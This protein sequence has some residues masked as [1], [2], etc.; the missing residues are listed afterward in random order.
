MN[1]C[2][3]ITYINNWPLQPFSQ[4]YGLASHTAHVVCVNFIHEWRDLQLK[5]DSAG[6]IFEKLFM[7]IFFTLGVFARTQLKEVAEEMFSFSCLTWGLKRSYTSNKPIHN[8]LDYGDFML[9]FMKIVDE[10]LAI[11]ETAIPKLSKKMLS[12]NYKQKIVLG[13]R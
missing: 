1:L 13:N 9:L 2:Y 7:A 10:P 12:S 5:V 8:P 11:T 6:H 4:D 3:Y